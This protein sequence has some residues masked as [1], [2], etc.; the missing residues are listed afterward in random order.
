ME[1]DPD[2][3]EDL[4]HFLTLALRDGLPPRRTSASD[5]LVDSDV[6]WLGEPTLLHDSK[7][8]NFGAVNEHGLWASQGG[9]SPGVLYWSKLAGPPV[10]M[11][12]STGMVMSIAADPKGSRAAI[13][14]VASKPNQMGVAMG[15]PGALMVVDA[16]KQ[17]VRTD[18]KSVV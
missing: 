12:L 8:T 18:R 4:V 7:Q 9:D 5:P 1:K 10:R 3:R 13:V 15:D 16:S 17:T 6:P 11:A 2:Y 14:F